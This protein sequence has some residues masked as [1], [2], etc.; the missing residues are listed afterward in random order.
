MNRWLRFELCGS[1]PARKLR[2]VKAEALV[3]MFRAQVFLV[4]GCKVDDDQPSSRPEHSR[5]L[6]DDLCRFLRIV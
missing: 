3:T 5:G 1:E 2:I 6:G 4:M